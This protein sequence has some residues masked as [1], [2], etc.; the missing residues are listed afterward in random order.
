MLDEEVESLTKERDAIRLKAVRFLN[1]VI[2]DCDLP[3]NIMS[4]AV[5][6]LDD[7]RIANEKLH[8]AMFK[9]VK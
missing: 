2:I 1:T 3:S 9:L 6:I 8:A 4:E 5:K 7:H